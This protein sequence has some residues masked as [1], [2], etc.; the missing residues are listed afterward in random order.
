MAATRAEALSLAAAHREAAA[1]GEAEALTMTEVAERSVVLRSAFE[2]LKVVLGTIGGFLALEEAKKQIEDILATGDKFKNFQIEFANAFGG[3]KEGEE[4]LSKVKEL[5][6][7]TPLSFEQVAKAALQARKEG[8]EPFSGSLLALINSNER[9]GGSAE[10]LSGLITDLG[11]ASNSGGISVK[12][13]TSL[14]QAGIPASQLLGDAIGKTSTQV[15][16]LAKKGQLG[17]DA[18]QTLLAAL[19]KSGADDAAQKM[20][21]IAAQTKNLRDCSR[22][23]RNLLQN[24]V[25]TISLF[26]S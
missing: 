16:E 24:P 5:A 20:G 18:V 22:T 10:D 23:S 21:T 3:A 4:A 7:Q 25:R 8:L 15:L 9:F 1:A 6:E 11:K 13:L 12:L 26:G 2:Q 19:T 14:Q 17:A